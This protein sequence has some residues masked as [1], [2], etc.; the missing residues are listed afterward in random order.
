MVSRKYKNGEATLSLFAHP[1]VTSPLNPIQA[2]LNI[3]YFR[4]NIR[5]TPPMIVAAGA[6]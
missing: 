5:I 2:L 6:N 4:M 1:I 3:G